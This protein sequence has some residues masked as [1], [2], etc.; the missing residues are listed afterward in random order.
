[1]TDQEN[2]KKPDT[3]TDTSKSRPLKIDPITILGTIIGFLVGLF[4]QLF[5]GKK[6][7]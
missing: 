3:T 7:Q 4:T 6:K 5:G 2:S 1:M